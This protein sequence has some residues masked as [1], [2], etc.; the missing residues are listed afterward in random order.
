V[1]GIDVAGLVE[2]VG[3][4]ATIAV[5]VVLWVLRQS[6]VGA[7]VDESATDWIDRLEGAL[8]AA[9]RRQRVAGELAAE[10]SAWV[11]ALLVAV[12]TANTKAEVHAA[13]EALG[14]PPRLI[15]V[16]E[17]WLKPTGPGRHAAADA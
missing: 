10:H 16:P 12:L 3:P 1:D 15:P 9:D 8:A 5:L 17:E 6:K 2:K 11:H 13:V 14:P 7:R 4:V